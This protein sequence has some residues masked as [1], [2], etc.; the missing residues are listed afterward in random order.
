MVRRLNLVVAAALVALPASAETA[1][2]VADL[3][4]GLGGG[5][6]ELHATE[7]AGKLVFAARDGVVSPNPIFLWEHDGVSPPVLVPG[8][9]GAGI[10]PQQFALWQSALYFSTNSGGGIWR[11]DGANAPAQVVGQVGFPL[12]LTAFTVPPSLDLLCFYGFAQG[13]GAELYCWD[14]SGTADLYQITAGEASSSPSGLTVFADELLF[15][16]TDAA[17]DRELWRFDGTNPPVRLTDLR[18]TGSSSPRA[19]TIVGNRLYFSALDDGGLPRLW[20]YDGANT[21]AIVSPAMQL[22]GVSDLGAFQGNLLMRGFEV[23]SGVPTGLWR[24]NG[25][26]FHRLPTSLASLFGFLNPVEHD[27]VLYWFGACG[28]SGSDLWR[29]PGVGSPIL[30]TDQFASLDLVSAGP[31][32]ALGRLYFAANDAVA[33]NELWQITPDMLLFADGFESGDTSVW[34]V[35]V[36]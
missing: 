25:S 30:V 7:L 18:A 8:Q 28:C 13:I 24:Y 2:R 31:V 36:P 4:T 5:I 29:W 9:V 27:G 16:A 15:A 1:V 23:G 17:G 33:G 21:P 10:Q 26:T 12:E 34:S 19:L 14:G 20:S 22:D 35:V 3:W 11:Y 32:S 6:F